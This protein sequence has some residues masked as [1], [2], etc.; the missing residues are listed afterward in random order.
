LTIAEIALAAFLQVRQGK[1]AEQVICDDDTNHVFILLCNQ[2]SSAR[3]DEVWNTSLLNLRKANKLALYPTTSRKAPNPDA[4]RYSNCVAQA[5]RLMERQF[6]ANVDRII[7]NPDMR[8]QFDAMVQYLLPGASVFESRYK[9]LTLRKTKRLRPEPVGQII[10]ATASSFLPLAEL[11]A[12]INEIPTASGVYIFVDEDKTLYVGKA[13]NL[14]RRVGDHVSTW[15]F[16]EL[17]SAIDNGSR[18]IAW[19]YFHALPVTCTARE[20][21]AYEQELIRSRRPEHNRAGK[22]FEE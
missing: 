3:P 13:D 6:D 14:R 15:A 22:T 1:S 7:C 11:E 5:V 4:K 16:R 18:G 20:L 17:I 9:A 12:R 2:S 21:S 19:I 8:C 10:R